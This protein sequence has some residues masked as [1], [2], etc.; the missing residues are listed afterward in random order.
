MTSPLGEYI[1]REFKHYLE[2]GTNRVQSKEKSN[3]ILSAYTAQKEAQKNKLEALNKSINEETLQELKNRITKEKIDI[4]TEAAGTV[5]QKQLDNYQ[6]SLGLLLKNLNKSLNNKNGLAIL[7]QEILGSKKISIDSF[8]A[9]KINIEELIELRNR[10]YKQIYDINKRYSKGVPIERAIIQ[11]LNNN[12]NDFMKK[13]GFIENNLFV[14]KSSSSSKVGKQTLK[15][16]KEIISSISISS[17]Y[18]ATFNG[19]FGENVVALTDDTCNNL[20]KTTVNKALKN[21]IKGAD[22]T[23]FQVTEEQVTSLVAKEYKEIFNNNIYQ[24]HASQDK[25]DVSVKINNS[26]L[27]ISVKAYTPKGNILT[28]HLQDVDLFYSLIATQQNFGTHWLNLHSLKLNNKFIDEK[29]EYD[30]ELLKQLKYEALASGNLLKRGPQAADTFVAI[31]VKNGRVYANSIFNI[32]NDSNSGIFNFR[33]SIFSDKFIFTNINS[34][35]NT[36]DISAERR[37]ALILGELRK[38][39]IAVS[40]KCKLDPK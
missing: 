16:I 17:A 11:S 31:D 24:V 39:K 29:K 7:G 10:I 21:N 23:S 30:N 14:L 20:T 19:K 15:A 2:Y 1:H 12:F 8:D 6:E 4:A 5:N 22:R 38:T 13:V 26:P 3:D 36:K 32:L 28:P 18:K 27:N 9:S 33:P 25:I 37:I 34:I 35:E 40:L